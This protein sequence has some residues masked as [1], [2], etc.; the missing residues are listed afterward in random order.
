MTKIKA[1]E[2]VRLVRKAP[3]FASEEAGKA[4]LEWVGISG[5]R[6]MREHFET[7]LK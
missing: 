5:M 1:G 2:R 7:A 6:K 3:F 4:L